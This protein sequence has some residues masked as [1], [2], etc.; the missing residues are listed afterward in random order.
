MEPDEDKI[1]DAVLALL[2]LTMHDESEFGCRAW[3]N[4]DWSVMDRLHQR[5]Y[6]D[7]PKNANKSVRMTP[8]GMKRSRELFDQLFTKVGSKS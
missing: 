6:L 3:K 2:S 7:N 5:G 8:D 1:D 4:F